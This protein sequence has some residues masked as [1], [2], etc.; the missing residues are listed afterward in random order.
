MCIRDSGGTGPRGHAA[1][2]RLYASRQK[3][4]GRL[5]GLNKASDCPEDRTTTAAAL[6]SP[7]GNGRQ[8]HGNSSVELTEMATGGPCRTCASDIDFSIGHHKGP[9]EASDCLK[10]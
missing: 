4:L 7:E 5:H 8:H 3:E 10:D 2:P 6:T 1:T 9:Y